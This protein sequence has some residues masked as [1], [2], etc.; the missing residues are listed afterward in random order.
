MSLICLVIRQYL[1]GIAVNAYARMKILRI[2]LHL[3][4]LMFAIRSNMQ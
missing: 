3:R 1:Q 4:S 2:I